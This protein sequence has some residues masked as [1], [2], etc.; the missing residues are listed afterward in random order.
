MLS[1]HGKTCYTGDS[2]AEPYRARLMAL[3]EIRVLAGP[4]HDE[5]R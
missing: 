3:V 4:K 5:P 1:E 2:G